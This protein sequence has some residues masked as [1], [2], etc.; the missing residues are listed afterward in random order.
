MQTRKRNEIS[1]QEEIVSGIKAKIDKLDVEMSLK[2]EEHE[3]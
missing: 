3:K 2:T 1:S